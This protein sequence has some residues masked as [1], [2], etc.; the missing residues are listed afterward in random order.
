MT[1]S[2]ARYTVK[3]YTSR[4]DVSEE[5][6]QHTAIRLEPLNPDYQPLDLAPDEFQVIGEFVQVLD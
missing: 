3:R 2:S 6:W 4:K 5:G 1:D